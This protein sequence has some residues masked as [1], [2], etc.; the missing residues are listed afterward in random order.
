MRPSTKTAENQNGN[1]SAL[2]ETPGAAVS[3]APTFGL[4]Y[5]HHGV[6]PRVAVGGP[7]MTRQADAADADIN[8]IIAKAKVTGFFPHAAEAP[9]FTDT[10]MTGRHYDEMV[11]SINKAEEAFMTIPAE[12]RRRFDNDPGKFLDFVQDPQNE[13]EL[14]TLGLLHPDDSKAF[15]ASQKRRKEQKDEHSEDSV[16]AKGRRAASGSDKGDSS[17]KKSDGGAD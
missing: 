14:V 2:R 13:E 8:N 5:R 1:D 15:Q 10:T 3:E 17:P 7:S 4:M 6:R 9:I 16:P 11:N 12:V